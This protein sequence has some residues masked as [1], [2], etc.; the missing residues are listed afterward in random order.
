M[1]TIDKTIKN[2][3][4]NTQLKPIH[5]PYEQMATGTNDQ[6]IGNKFQKCSSLA[7]REQQ[8]ERGVENKDKDYSTVGECV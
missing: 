8:R 5:A 4:V 3:Q 1:Q 2:Q 6:R 7:K